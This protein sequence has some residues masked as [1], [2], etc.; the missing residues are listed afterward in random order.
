MLKLMLPFSL[1][2]RLA[3]Y[4]DFW[5]V[6]NFW[7]SCSAKCWQNHYKIHQLSLPW[8]FWLLVNVEVS[9]LWRLHHVQHADGGGVE[10]VDRRAA[11]WLWRRAGRSICI[12]LIFPF[13]TRGCWWCVGICIPC[14]CNLPL[15]LGTDLCHEQAVRLD[16]LLVWWLSSCKVFIKSLKFFMCELSRWSGREQT[17]SSQVLRSTT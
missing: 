5:K 14:F 12:F 6:C 3:E 7:H 8:D 13:L 9:R 4:L 10:V 17:G 11:G 16:G 1:C 2:T 15:A